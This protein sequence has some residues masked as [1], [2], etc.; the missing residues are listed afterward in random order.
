MQLEYCSRVF[1]DAC[2]QPMFF[3]SI[4]D[5][6]TLTFTAKDPCSEGIC[7]HGSGCEFDGHNTVICSCKNG[8]SGNYCEIG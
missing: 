7:K 8:Y 5:V 3:C 1:W 6:D 2:D 4:F